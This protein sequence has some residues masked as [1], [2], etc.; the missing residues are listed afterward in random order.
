MNNQ[1]NDTI[2]AI[3]LY[4]AN[5]DFSSILFI[6][7]QLDLLLVS[8]ALR[9][10]NGYPAIDNKEIKFTNPH[11]PFGIALTHY[12]FASKELLAEIKATLE[13]VR[14]KVDEQNFRLAYNIYEVAQSWSIAFEGW[15]ADNERQIALAG[16]QQK[17]LLS[18]QD[19]PGNEVSAL[20][21][22]LPQHREVK[23]VEGQMGLF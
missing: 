18:L 3:N 11:F 5:A 21:V 16:T 2:T 22:V 17:L 6:S 14:G 23:S 10:P 9:Q 4:I 8:D 13:K 7:K 12:Y 19:A 20:D 1:N 15:V